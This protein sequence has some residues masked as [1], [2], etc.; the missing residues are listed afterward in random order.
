MDRRILHPS[1]KT[2][3]QP[4]VHWRHNCLWLRCSEILFIGQWCVKGK[5]KSRNHMMLEHKWTQ[6][7]LN[8]AMNEIYFRLSH[9]L[10]ILLRWL[11]QSPKISFLC[12]QS[13]ICIMSWDSIKPA[14]YFT[15]KHQMGNGAVN[16]DLFLWKSG[17]EAGTDGAEESWLTPSQKTAVFA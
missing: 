1:K 15:T 9:A 13:E 6:C 16:I 11:S 12:T 7:D 2:S 4:R 10:F 3:L 8:F 5:K 14:S 17:H